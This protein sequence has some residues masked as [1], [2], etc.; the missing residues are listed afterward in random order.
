[1]VVPHGFLGHSHGLTSYP[2]EKLT[3]IPPLNSLLSGLDS[4]WI[5]PD[6][7]PGAS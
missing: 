6:D 4:I 2:L 5:S 7:N 1:M 3:K